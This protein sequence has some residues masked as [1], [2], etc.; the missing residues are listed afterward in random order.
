MSQKPEQPKQ[1]GK[2]QDADAHSDETQLSRRGLIKTGGAAAAGAGL[3]GLAGLG[4]DVA[5]AQTQTYP[6]HEVVIKLSGTQ[7]DLVRAIRKSA[8][9]PN[10]GLEVQILEA[11]LATMVMSRA[12]Q[13]GFSKF[14]LGL[15]LNFSLR[16]RIHR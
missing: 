11:A 13:P 10:H 16:L 6:P 7:A 3:A 4:A 8:S 2:T 12:N 5:D 1:P 15:D 14:A 9:K